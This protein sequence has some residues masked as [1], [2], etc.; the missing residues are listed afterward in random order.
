MRRPRQTETDMDLITLGEVLADPELRDDP[1]L[2]EG[3]ARLLAGQPRYQR[4][5]RTG[6]AE[7]I[8]RQRRQC[9]GK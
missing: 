7:F 6:A 2:Q 3:V 9:R 8:R 5:P 4:T 1:K